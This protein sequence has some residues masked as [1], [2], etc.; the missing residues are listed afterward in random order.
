MVTGMAVWRGM[1]LWGSTVAVVNE[2][3][4][5]DVFKPLGEG[6]DSFGDA[7]GDHEGGVE[8]ARL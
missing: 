6:D 4:D 7:I 5:V 2:G 1:P 3:G 8:F